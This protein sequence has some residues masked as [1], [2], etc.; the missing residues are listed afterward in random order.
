[1]TVCWPPDSDTRNPGDQAEVSA[2][3]LVG[4]AQAWSQSPFPRLPGPDLGEGRLC[5]Q[6]RLTA[7]QTAVSARSTVRRNP[8][9]RGGCHVLLMVDRGEV[10]GCPP[11]RPHEHPQRCQSA[12]HSPAASTVGR[13]QGREA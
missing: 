2:L 12:S 7:G 5:G 6:K 13:W 8:G 9:W 10:T 4:G 11:H 1:M 3:S